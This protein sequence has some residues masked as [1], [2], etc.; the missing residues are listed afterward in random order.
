MWRILPSMMGRTVREDNSLVLAAPAHSFSLYHFL[1][2]LGTGVVSD[3]MASVSASPPV[4]LII[5]EEIPQPK[6]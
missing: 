3:S 6:E 4:D 5:I 1:L 2:S